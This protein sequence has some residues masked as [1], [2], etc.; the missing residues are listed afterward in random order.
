M[1]N[2]G[3][4]IA[5]D[6]AISIVAI[7]LLSGIS[8]FLQMS[9]NMNSSMDLASITQIADDWN[10]LPLVSITITEGYS[11][12][13]GQASIWSKKWGGTVEGCDCTG[14]WAASI[15]K[16]HLQVDDRCYDDDEYY[17]IWEPAKMPMIQDELNDMRICGSR[18]GQ[19]FANA[20]RPNTNNTCPSGTQKC[21]NNTVAADTICY[22]TYDNRDDVCPVTGMQFVS[23]NTA[24]TFISNK[25]N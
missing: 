4:K 25:R 15:W 5:V 1:A 2:D 17:C 3:R 24:D 11:C 6:C 7:I 18:G 23:K 8:Y 10:T 19:S 16:Q 22:S 14:S 20:V 12:P 13:W 9:S 21:S